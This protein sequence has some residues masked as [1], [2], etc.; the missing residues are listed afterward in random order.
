M[1]I[2]RSKISWNGWGWAAHKDALASREEVWTW[3]AHELGMPSLLATPPRDLKDITL[4]ATR[5]STDIREKLVVM[6]GQDR[7]R[8][9]RGATGW[10]RRRG[11]RGA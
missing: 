2:D 11:V 3:L 10:Q 7:V 5:L 9:D 4:P 1:S 6:L 8:D